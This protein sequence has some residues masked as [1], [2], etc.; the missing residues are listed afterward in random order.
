VKIA[1]VAYFLGR[2]SG[3]LKKVL[4]QLRNWSHAGHTV[5]LFGLSREDRLWEG[6]ESLPNDI[7]LNV[8]AWNLAPKT[9]QLVRNVLAWNPQLVYFRYG[10]YLPFL[11]LIPRRL[12]TILEIN[13]DDLAECRVTFPLHQ[14]VY[15][16][17]TRT[18]LLKECSGLITVT[19]ELADRHMRWKKPVL[20]T[21]NG[22][23][24]GRYPIL[25]GP[26]NQKPRLIFTGARK[27]PWHGLDKVIDLAA[28]AP[29]WQFDVIGARAEDV[30]GDITSNMFFHGYLGWAQYERYMKRADVAIG[31]LALHRI[32]MNEASPLKVR[33]YLAY[34]IPTVIGYKDT[35]FSNPPTFILQ[36][37]NTPDNVSGNFKRIE[38]FVASS[39]GKRISRDDISHIDS[40]EKEARRLDFFEHILKKKRV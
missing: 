17:L 35:D 33:E 28:R 24:L 40:R 16:L 15:L 32:G 18:L 34:G 12:P 19:Q 6:G 21:A 37:A 14:Y 25:P 23:D 4:D 13:S 8:C 20:V 2:E 29:E 36:L 5:R 30:N 1:Y 27:Y 9:R 11:D 39:R 10:V 22:I 31:S 26:H 38:Q 7:N 3:V